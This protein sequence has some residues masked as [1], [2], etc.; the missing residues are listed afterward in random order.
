MR[1]L[2]FLAGVM[3]ATRAGAQDEGPSDALAV[4][5][6]ALRTGDSTV[7]DSMVSE[8]ALENVQAMLDA[9]RMNM[10]SDRDGVVQRLNSA[11]YGVTA[12]EV[13]D[14][15]AREYLRRTVALPV[16]MARYMPYEMQV[17][18]SSLDDGEAAASLLFS[19]A[20]GFTMESEALLVME[21]GGWKVSTFLGLN[22][23][24]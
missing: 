16:M 12:D 21:D 23:F 1:R 3:A 6:Q 18:E 14:W 8:A 24:P 15:D 2:V 22:S 13:S 11:G 7:V 5:F 20:S 10:R 4:F 17:V 19:T 9:L